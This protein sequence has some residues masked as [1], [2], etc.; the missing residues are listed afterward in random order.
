MVVKPRP[1]QSRTSRRPLL[2]LAWWAVMAA[3]VFWTALYLGAAQDASLPGFTYV[4]F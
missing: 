3:S 4:N 2:R 1:G